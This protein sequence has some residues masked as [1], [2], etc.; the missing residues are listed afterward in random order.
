MREDPGAMAL[1]SAQRGLIDEKIAHARVPQW[2]LPIE[3]VRSSFRA[4]WSPAMTGDPVAV[5][6]VEDRTLETGAG[7][8]KARVYTPEADDPAPIMMYFHGDGYVKGGIVET[9]AF[10]RRLAKTTGHIVVSVDY[11]LTLGL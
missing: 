11:R 9:D 5:A 4:L 2:Q 10:C 8:V 3:E 1:H 6:N 7:P